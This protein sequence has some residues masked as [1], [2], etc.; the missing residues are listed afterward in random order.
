MLNTTKRVFI[1][2]L[3][4]M[5]Y[6][7]VCIAGIDILLLDALITNNCVSSNLALEI[8]PLLL[9]QKWDVNNSSS[10]K[11]YKT[12]NFIGRYSNTDNSKEDFIVESYSNYNSSH[13]L[14]TLIN[15][16]SKA[17]TLHQNCSN[18]DCKILKL[19][20][21]F[22][23]IAAKSPLNNFLNPSETLGTYM[24]SIKNIYLKKNQWRGDLILEKFC[25]N[26]V[27]IK[28]LPIVDIRFYNEKDN[29]K[30]KT[31]NEIDKIFN[32]I[33][34]KNSKS[35][36]LSIGLSREFRGKRW[37]QINTI[38]IIEI[39][40]NKNFYC[41]LC[42]SK[43]EDYRQGRPSINFPIFKCSNKNCNQGNGYPWSSWNPNEFT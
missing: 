9:N 16:L 7:F 43:V 22:A 17:A 25:S 37:L 23:I 34:N 38:H 15:K 29:F 1:T 24:G 6:P 35:Y 3:T 27:V 8:R 14:Q 30:A 36:L 28:D 39:A 5:K 12:Y 20:N 11:L 41:P 26:Q 13:D 19:I 18:A 21:N 4:R 42:N 31:F 2:H 10:I 40:E 33:I 32:N